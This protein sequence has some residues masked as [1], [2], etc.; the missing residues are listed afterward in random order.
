M[1]P[2]V[3]RSWSPCGQTPVLVQRTRSHKKVSVIA[4]LCV[5]PRRDHMHL[6]FRLHPDTHINA[7][8]IIA[9]LRQLHQ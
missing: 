7:V 5:A 3:R 9:F 8:L 2:L 1:A 6:Y 4:A